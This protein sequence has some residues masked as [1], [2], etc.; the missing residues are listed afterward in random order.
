MAFIDGDL[1]ERAIATPTGTVEVLAEI[2]VR[3]G[4]AGRL[5]LRDIAIYPRGGDVLPVSPGELLG[6]AHLAVDEM[7]LAGFTEVRITGTRLSGARP[8]RRVDL[9][10]GLERKQP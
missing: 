6:W 9:V 8:G 2:V 7:R 4:V 5:E 10:I 1:Y 3:V